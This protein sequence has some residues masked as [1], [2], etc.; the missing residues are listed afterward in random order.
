VEP[1]A[2]DDL[3]GSEICYSVIFRLYF[4]D[5]FF[6][7]TSLL[8]APRGFCGFDMIYCYGSA[9]SSRGVFGVSLDYGVEGRE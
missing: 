6:S 3:G 7:T 2:R 4:Y 5:L 1:E 8:R 9:V